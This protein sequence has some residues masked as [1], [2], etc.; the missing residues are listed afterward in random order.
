MRHARNL[1]K[2][3]RL[4]A[5]LIPTL[6][7]GRHSS[8]P[9]LPAWSDEE[10]AQRDCLL[11]FLFDRINY[12][13]LPAGSYVTSD[14][15]LQ[16]ME[17]LLDRLG[18]PQLE[19]PVIHIAG[20]KGK[21]T[22]ATLTAQLLK[23]AGLKIGLFTSPHI[24]RFEE[25]MT[26]NGNMPTVPE[27]E[28]ILSQLRPVLSNWE[29][30][31][32]HSTPTFFE[33]CTAMAW[34][35]FRD[36]QVD[37]AV[38]EVGLGG[39]LDA[40]N[41]CHP[42]VCVITSISRDH[43]HLLGND[44]ASI[45]KEKAGIIKPGIPVISG[46]SAPEARDV[47][48]AVSSAMSC[49]LIEVD[50]EIHIEYCQR[51]AMSATNP[52]MRER[53]TI[54]APHGR[55][56]EVLLPVPGSHHARNAA[57]ALVAVETFLRRQP[58]LARHPFE[59]SAIASACLPLRGEVVGTAPLILIDGAHNE[60][61]LQ[62]VLDILTPIPIERR[63]LIFGVSRDK[64]ARS[65]LRL[66]NGGFSQIVLTAYQ[67][68]PRALPVSEL[69]ELAA[70]ELSSSPWTMADDPESA[71][72]AV[73][74]LSD[75]QDVICVTGSIFLGAEVREIILKRETRTPDSNGTNS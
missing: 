31:T 24:H 39:R 73:K 20:T 27:L 72:A 47:V 48:R 15:K 17:K 42:Q 12:E 10:C 74:S 7:T 35:L 3:A 19:I 43:M 62:S 56:E 40:T 16:R 45:A 52:L 32:S 5:P 34:L 26:V 4:N 58:A 21:G 75:A 28:R 61:S 53:V 8:A 22:T 59:A 70:E 33:V 64:D 29:A 36:Q 2:V 68:N 25:R 9:T 6:G 13:R 1:L 37:A 71:L 18:N 63:R 57:L 54:A 23:S 14:F 66:L 49:E 51:V 50:R 65:M 55:Y 46:V 69:A 41:V 38:L 60:A 67:S 30:D 44:L 11:S